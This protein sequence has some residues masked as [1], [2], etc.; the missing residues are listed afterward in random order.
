MIAEHRDDRDR[1]AGQLLDERDRLFRS[2][3]VR[4]IATEAEDVGFPVESG[5]E[6]DERPVRL[7]SDVQVGDRR[8]AA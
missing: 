6:A 8:D 5:E 2:T 4:E 3:A 1:D 7:L